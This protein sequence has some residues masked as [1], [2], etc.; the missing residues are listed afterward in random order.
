MGLSDRARALV[1]LRRRSWRVRWALLGALGSAGPSA[2]VRYAVVWVLGIAFP[3]A[4]PVAT[5][6]V[7]GL[8]P[9]AIGGGLGSSAGRRLLGSLVV[10]AVVFIG[11]R[12]IDPLAG[13][14][15]KDVGLRID[16]AVQERLMV[17]ASLPPGIEHLEDDGVRSSLALGAGPTGRVALSVPQL[18]AR[19]VGAVG[20]AAIIA[21]SSLPVA[22]LVVVL[23]LRERFFWRG[24]FLL[25]ADAGGKTAMELLRADYFAEL[26]LAPAAAKETRVFGLAAW[27]AA[28]YSDQWWTAQQPRWDWFN[29]YVRSFV[30]G[31]PLRFIAYAVPYGLLADLAATGRIG[32][33]DF[34]AGAQATM[35]VLGLSA[36]AYEDLTLSGQAHVY[37]EAQ[38]VEQDLRALPRRSG[39]ATGPLRDELRF[40]NVSFTYAGRDEPVLRGLDLTLSAGRST[41]LVGVNGAGK[42]TIVKLLAGLYTPTEGRILADGVDL[43]TVDADSWRRQLAVVF[44]DF[45]RYQASAADNIAFGSPDHLRDAAEIERAAL[46][47]DI[48]D[49]ISTLPASWETMLSRQFPGGAELSGGQWQRVAIAR[50][51]F[52]IHQ[53]ASVL[54]LDEPTANLD[55]RAEAD[56]FERLLALTAGVTTLLI[57]HRFSTV[58]RAD[59]ILVLEDGHVVERGAHDELLALDGRYAHMFRL[60]ANRFGA[61]QVGEVG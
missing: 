5:G 29:D 28:R 7:I 44:Q 3:L 48:A 59:T 14:V 43:A 20:G 56:L 17:A 22:A 52:A 26:V 39:G 11:Q 49:A 34:I 36:I 19:Y 31:F 55:V 38:K 6:V 37:P 60:Q 8:V 1:E 4:S 30:V 41:A 53:G 13:I 51:L 42:T 33:G 16:A 21:R 47:A 54:V 32:L 24:K 12:L 18:A 35:Y 9:A 57:S 61:T 50:A 23:F 15:A 45:A 46:D 40:D 2:L 58:R 27:K 10:L 25:M